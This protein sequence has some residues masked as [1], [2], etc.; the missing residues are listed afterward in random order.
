MKLRYAVYEG[1]NFWRISFSSGKRKFRDVFLVKT[2]GSNS[3]DAVAGFLL[4]LSRGWVHLR[5]M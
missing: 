3:D 2:K 5:D 4:A 1:P